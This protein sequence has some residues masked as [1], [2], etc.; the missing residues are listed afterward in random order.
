MINTQ[1]KKFTSLKTCLV[2]SLAVFKK[3]YTVDEETRKQFDKYKDSQATCFNCGK[4]GHFKL[5][6]P[7]P[8]KPFVPRDVQ[9]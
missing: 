9:H 7:Y 4:M 1:S 3:V 6:C 8:K 5:N 2:P